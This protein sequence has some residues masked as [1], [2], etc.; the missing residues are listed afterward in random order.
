[1]SQ[2]KGR[3]AYYVLSESFRCGAIELESLSMC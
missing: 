3:G 1:M 2:T